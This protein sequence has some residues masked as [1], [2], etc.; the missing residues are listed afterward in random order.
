MYVCIYIY[1]I[2][3]IQLYKYN[4]KIVLQ[5]SFVLFPP[6]HV[7]CSPSALRVINIVLFLVLFLF[8]FKWNWSTARAFDSDW[9]WNERTAAIGRPSAPPSLLLSPLRYLLPLVCLDI[10]KLY[11]LRLGTDNK[12]SHYFPIPLPIRLMWKWSMNIVFNYLI[13]YFTILVFN[14]FSTLVYLPVTF[15]PRTRCTWVPTQCLCKSPS[16]VIRNTFWKYIYI[17]LAIWEL[18]CTHVNVYMWYIVY[19]DVCI[20]NKQIKLQLQ[21]GF[22]LGQFTM[23][24]HAN[25]CHSVC[26]CVCVTWNLVF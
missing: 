4:S 16:I 14:C 23:V 15:S 21:V 5:F 12:L 20:L 24:L 17:Y 9:R 7:S 10:R 19:A 2:L 6:C 3:H 1:L 8:I 18:T 22:G 11:I 13:S 25:F 26:L